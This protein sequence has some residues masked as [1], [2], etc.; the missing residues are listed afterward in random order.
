M[1]FLFDWILNPNFGLKIIALRIINFISFLFLTIIENIILSVGRIFNNINF[2]LGSEF[3]KKMIEGNGSGSSPSG[4][5]PDPND[6]KNPFKKIINYMKDLPDKLKKKTSDNQE[7]DKQEDTNSVENPQ[8]S[9]PPAAATPTQPSTAKAKQLTNPGDNLNNSPQGIESSSSNVLPENFMFLQW[10]KQMPSISQVMDSYSSFDN[11]KSISQTNI[12][13]LR[14]YIEDLGKK[15]P[16]YKKIIET[17]GTQDPYLTLNKLAT[18]SVLRDR[19]IPE[20][21][22][23][24]FVNS[25]SEYVRKE[26]DVAVIYLEKK[27]EGKTSGVAIQE[28]VQEAAD[29][30]AAAEIIEPTQEESDSDFGSD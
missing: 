9:A 4:R 28:M 12:E 5:S 8:T 17:Y 11:K 14:E 22:K 15:N 27:S 6:P 10:N 20:N 19:T 25:L 29:Q 18:D 7:K 1:I 30:R 16:E 26:P 21:Q 23:E 24:D 3:F 13:E 2:I